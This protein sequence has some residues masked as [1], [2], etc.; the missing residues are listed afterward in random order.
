MTLDLPTLN[1]LLDRYRTATQM[2]LRGQDPDP[3]DLFELAMDVFEHADELLV[4]A[5]TALLCVP[6]VARNLPCKPALVSS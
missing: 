6:H 4:L 2:K 3:D 5:K 1:C